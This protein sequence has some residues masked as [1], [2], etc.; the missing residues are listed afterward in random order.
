MD[1]NSAVI[2]SGMQT[3]RFWAA[4]AVFTAVWVTCVNC[5]DPMSFFFGGGGVWL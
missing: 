5:V 3:A 2:Y 1:I 4:A